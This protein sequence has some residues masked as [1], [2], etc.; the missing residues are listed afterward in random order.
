VSSTT[1]RKAHEVHPITAVQSEYSL[2]TRDPELR[3]LDTCHELGIGFVPFS[4]LGRAFLCGQIRKPEDL[5]EDDMRRGM[6]RFMDENLE[7]NVALLTTY[8]TIA[9]DNSCTMAQLA[10]AWLLAQGDTLVPIPGTKH[11][12]YA[13]EN[14]KAADLEISAADLARAGEIISQ[15]TVAGPRYAESQMISL[16]A[17][18]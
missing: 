14:A 8:E 12:S 7:S 16:D 9:L 10:L 6:P 13:E 3:V 2:W 15:D 18:E 5:A 11:V 1:L 17:E 4:P